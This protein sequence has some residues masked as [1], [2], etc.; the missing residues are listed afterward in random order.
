[1]KCPRCGAENSPQAE[2]C[3]LCEYPFTDSTIIP[4]GPTESAPPQAPPPG[5]PETQA[6]PPPPGSAPLPTVE[7][8][9]VY[10]PGY[11]PTP[12]PGMS[13]GKKILIGAGAA[14]GVVVLVL[15]F[16]LVYFKP[17]PTIKV[18]TPPGWENATEDMKE[19]F[20]EQV[21]QGGEEITLDYLFTDGSL[22]NSI[23]VAHGKA[24]IMDSPDSDSLE[25]VE[26]F[27]M[28][29]KGELE[30]EFKSAYS[31]Q[32]ASTSLTE[33][34]V[35]EMANGI[36][37]LFMSLSVSGQGITIYQDFMFFFN[38]NTMFFTVISSLDDAVNQEAVDFL[39]E[40]IT[41]E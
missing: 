17:T 10:A 41:F 36:P 26:D 1:M 24:Y 20:E 5:H 12:T 29:H 11:P 31:D 22:S 8:P 33:Y 21:S 40:N 4:E 18:P 15:V 25:D 6:Q 34:R 19:S 38:D 27:F 32:G 16:V 39:T 7:A 9:G 28:Q 37:S 30:G 2:W 14:L 3:Y 23:A 13:T 35:A